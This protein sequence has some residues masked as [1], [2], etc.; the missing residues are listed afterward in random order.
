MPD[1]TATTGVCGRIHLFVVNENISSGEEQPVPA[2]D[3]ISRL[4]Y[5]SAYGVTGSLVWYPIAPN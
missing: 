3:R 1:V 2:V 4:G 5:S